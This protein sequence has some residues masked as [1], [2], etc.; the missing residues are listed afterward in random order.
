MVQ[1]PHCS[2]SGRSRPRAPIATPSGGARPAR[3][4]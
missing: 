3:T 4:G 1:E 2:V